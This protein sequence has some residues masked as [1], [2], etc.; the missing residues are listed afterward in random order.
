MCL[1]YLHC[2]RAY[3]HACMPMR[4]SPTQDHLQVHHFYI[5]LELYPQMGV[6][7]RDIEYPLALQP[8]WE[9]PDELSDQLSPHNSGALSYKV[10][11]EMSMSTPFNIMCILS[12]NMCCTQYGSQ[13]VLKGTC[14]VGLSQPNKIHGNKLQK[15]IGDTYIHNWFIQINCPR[16]SGYLSEEESGPYTAL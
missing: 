4:H 9:D 11:A 7:I 5:F 13:F 10:C 16:A 6:A 2:V 3:L 8:T 15:D 12:C 14:Y 1:L